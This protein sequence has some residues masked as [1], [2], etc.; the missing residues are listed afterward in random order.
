M[1]NRVAGTREFVQW[2]AA[3]LPK[4]TYV[5]IMSQYRVEFMAFDFPLIARAITSEEFVESVRWAKEAG[6]T[7]LDERTLSHFELHRRRAS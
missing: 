6:L 3:N 5:N 1:P 2:V 7:N 4:E